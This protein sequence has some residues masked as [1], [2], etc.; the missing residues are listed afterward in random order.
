[1][2]TNTTRSTLFKDSLE[3][4]DEKIEQEILIYPNPFSE[5]T[6]IHFAEELTEKHTVIIHNILGQVVYRNENVTGT[7]LEIK[8][9]QL[10]V[11]VYILSLFNSDSEELFSTKL[12]VE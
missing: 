9:E 8:K 2:V 6:I 3:V 12:L 7:S 1:M 4:T 10:G 11:G 5:Y